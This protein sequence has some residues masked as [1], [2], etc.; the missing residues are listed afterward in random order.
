MVKE[1]KIANRAIGSDNPVFI[2]AELSCNHQHDYALAKKTIKA[3]KEA[4]A[5]AVK[6]STDSPGGLTLDSDNKY[7]QINQGTSWDGQTLYELYQ[8]VETPWEWQPRLKKYAEKLGLICFSTPCDREA[9][10]FLEKIHVPAYKIASFEI[11][12]YDFVEYVAKK[13]KPIIIS[14]GIAHQDEIKDV[15]NLC[16][17]AGNDQIIILKCTS[18]YPASPEEMN[19]LTIADIKK[20]FKVEVGLSDH[21]LSSVVPLVAI[22]LGARVVEKHFILS[23]S[24]GGPDAEF[25]IE[26]EEFKKMVEDIRVV[27]KAMG[28]ITYELDD[29]SRK[30]R[31]FSRSLFAVADISKGGVFTNKNVRSIR[32]G[33][34][35]HPKF[36]KTVLGKRAKKDIRRGTP[37]DLKEIGL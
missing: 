4:G 32:P 35:L 25:S 13:G 36:L 16:R 14:T 22:A 8:K 23:R 9:V 30:N 1:I 24:L 17:K 12:D 10:D 26:P 37:L 6:L 2:I 5:D 31:E 11:T 34:G 3:M 27:E 33:F 20:R 7:F 21:S 15:I 29:H 18:S 28:K 19:L